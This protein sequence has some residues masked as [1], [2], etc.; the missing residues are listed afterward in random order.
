MGKNSTWYTK[1]IGAF[2]YLAIILKQPSSLLLI[3]LK[4][5]YLFNLNKN[6]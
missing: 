4:L 1:Y 5:G 6:G 3:K 2:N